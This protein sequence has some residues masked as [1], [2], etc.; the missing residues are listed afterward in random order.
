MFSTA[1]TDPFF[2]LPGKAP[3]LSGD[4]QSGR[5]MSMVTIPAISGSASS[6]EKRAFMLPDEHVN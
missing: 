6:S 1:I 5:F 3:L 4:G 2:I